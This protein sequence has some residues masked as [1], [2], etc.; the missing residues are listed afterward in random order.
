MGQ[1][2]SPYSPRRSGESEGRVKHSTNCVCAQCQADQ[3]R[4]KKKHSA[5]N[6][7]TRYE[8]DRLAALPPVPANG[9]ADQLGTAIDNLIAWEEAQHG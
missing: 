5:I 3:L 8:R 1:R 4:E 7:L 9:G 2:Q 6:P